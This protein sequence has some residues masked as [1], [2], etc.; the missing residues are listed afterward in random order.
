MSDVGGPQ[1]VTGF[2]NEQRQALLKFATSCSRGPL[3]GF[4]HL[5]PPLRIH[6]V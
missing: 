6:K 3:G 5:V 2:S 4:R 1:V